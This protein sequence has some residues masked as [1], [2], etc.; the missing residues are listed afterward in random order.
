MTTTPAPILSAD[1]GAR[2]LDKLE[3]I[4][5]QLRSLSERQR[6]QED[7]STELWADATALAKVAM[8]ATTER[9]DALERDGTL[10]KVRELASVAQEALAGFS[11]ADVRELRSS[12]VAILEAVRALTQPAV[13]AVAADAAGAIEHAAEVKPIGI[14]GVVKATR[15]DDV[16]KGMAVLF[17][18]MRRIGHAASAASTRDQALADKRA[19][20]NEVLGAKRRKVLGVE[21]PKALPAGRPAP[22][23]KAAPAA[24]CAAPTPPKPVATVIDGV[25][26]SADGHLADPAAWTRD[27]ASNLAALSGLALTEAHWKLLEAARAEFTASGVSPNIRRLTEVAGL[28]TRDIYQLFPKAPGRTLAKIAGLPKPAGCL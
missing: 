28:T 16:Q 11:A 18:I 24:S 7:R 5:A 19:R 6:Q 14:F 25:A 22:A 21:R 26:F 20:L 8:T 13:L 1:L 4:D 10:G 23:P 17:E 15:D 3:A 9:L 12:I 27:L 2:V